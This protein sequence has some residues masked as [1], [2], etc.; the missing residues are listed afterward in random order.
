M[1]HR[2]NVCLVYTPQHENIH[3]ENKKKTENEKVN[4][5]DGEGGYVGC[6]PVTS[7]DV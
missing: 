4:F 7:V 1:G 2:K 6:F 5:Y 3:T